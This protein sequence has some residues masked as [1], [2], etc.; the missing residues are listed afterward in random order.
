MPC[1]HRACIAPRGAVLDSG[2]PRPDHALRC[3]PGGEG[4]G[5]SEVLAGLEPR[6]EL[7][8]GSPQC[9]TEPF[10]KPPNAIPW[11]ENSLHIYC[12]HALIAGGFSEAVVRPEERC[13]AVLPRP[14]QSLDDRRILRRY[15]LTR[16]TEMKPSGASNHAHGF[17]ASSAAVAAL[18]QSLQTSGLGSPPDQRGR[19]L[20]QAIPPKGEFD[21]E[22]PSDAVQLPVRAGV[23]GGNGTWQGGAHA[24][25][26]GPPRPRAPAA[27]VGAGSWCAEAWDVHRRRGGRGEGG[28]ARHD[29]RAPTPRCPRP[30]R[31]PQ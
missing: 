20:G 21:L 11:P 9:G 2:P 12:A 8:V 14:N 29:V 27:S 3:E 16:M 19:A 1:G 28:R 5:G 6:Q 24:A 18:E 4:R 25:R 30:R 10:S 13:V 23:L 31:R 26:V 22:F 15:Q 7:G 17:E